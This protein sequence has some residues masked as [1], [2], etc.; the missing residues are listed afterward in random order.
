V[1]NELGHAELATRFAPRPQFVENG[2]RDTV[3]PTV[4]VEREFARMQAVFTW[5]GAGQNAELEN[6]PGPHRVWAEGAF[7]FLERHLRKS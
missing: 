2:L 5:L 6:F 3:T 1:L 7:R 4:W